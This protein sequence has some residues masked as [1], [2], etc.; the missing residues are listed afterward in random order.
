MVWLPSKTIGMLDAIAQ[1]ADHVQSAQDAT[2]LRRHAGMIVR[3]AREAV[4]KAD[5]VLAVETRFTADATTVLA[6]KN[7]L[8]SGRL[9]RFKNYP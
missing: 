5:D 7:S 6:V 9:S 2:C 4:P 8:Q 1:I 3:G